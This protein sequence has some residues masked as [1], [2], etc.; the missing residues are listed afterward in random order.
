MPI[1]IKILI[2]HTAIHY[3]SSVYEAP[4]VYRIQ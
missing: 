4:I 3:F 2:K 1:D